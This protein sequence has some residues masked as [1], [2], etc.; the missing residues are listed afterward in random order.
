MIQDDYRIDYMQK[1]LS[2]CKKAVAEG[3]E[4]MGYCSWSFI[5]LLSTSHGFQKRY[6][7]VYVDR[8]DE[9]ER[10]LKRIPKKSYYWYQKTIS[11]KGKDL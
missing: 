2:E 8:D 5:D 11:N 10:T 9:S 4:L 6:G 3:V 7:L 1:H